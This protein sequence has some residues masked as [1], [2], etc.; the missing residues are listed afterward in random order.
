MRSSVGDPK[1]LKQ[2]KKYEETLKGN[3]TEIIKSYKIVCKNLQELNLIKPQN[4]DFIK[5]VSEGEN[6]SIDYFPKLIIFGFDQDQRD[7]VNWKNHHETLK[8]ALQDRLILRG[9]VN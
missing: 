7:G 8:V 3:E 5:R 9:N 2:I 6:I 1:V 4:D